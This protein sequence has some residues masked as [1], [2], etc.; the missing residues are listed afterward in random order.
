LL[1]GL[2]YLRILPA[3]VLAAQVVCASPM[4]P[5]PDQNDTLAALSLEQLTKVEVTSVAR[6]DQKLLKAAAAVYVITADDIRR[7]G[8]ASVPDVLRFVPGVEVAQISSD[9][10]AITAR[11]FNGTHRSRSGTGRDHVG[12]QCR[13]RCDQHYHEESEEYARLDGIESDERE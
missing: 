3:A 7:S 13:R 11:G 8:A 12:R 5:P 2:R 4:A 1:T 10:W 9:V 6:K